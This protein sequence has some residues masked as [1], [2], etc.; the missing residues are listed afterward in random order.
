MDNVKNDSYYLNKMV[1]DLEFMIE[2]TKGKTSDEIE[3]NPLLMD[4]IM[5]RLVQIAE[6]MTHISKEYKDSHNNIRWGQISGFRKGIV[7]DY[8]RTDYS[9][10]YEIISKDIY[11]LKEDL[12]IDLI[13]N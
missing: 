13:T 3:A 4:S 2:H 1:A 8:G 6:N 9:I 12:C 10:V 7:H 11:K 5:F